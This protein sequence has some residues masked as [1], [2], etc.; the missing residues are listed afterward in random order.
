MMLAMGR[1]R[2]EN[3]KD[4]PKDFYP[5]AGGRG[6]YRMKNPVTGLPKSLKTKDKDEAL[7][8][9]WAIKNHY[10][11]TI[12]VKAAT[13][14]SG[15]LLSDIATQYRIEQLPIATSK[16]NPLDINTKKTYGN[17]LKNIHDATCF[18][19]PV[20]V[21]DDVDEGPRIVRE[22]LSKWINK[23]KTYN[24]RLSCLSRL[25]AWIVDM[26]KLVRNPC[27]PINHRTPTKREVYMTDEHYLLI[28]DRLTEKFG[29][30]YARALDW[31]YIMS[32]RPTNMM[33]VQESHIHEKEIHYYAYKNDSPVI[34]DRDDVIDELVAWFRAYKR[35]QG[36]FTQYLIVHPAKAQRGLAKRPIDSGRLYRYFKRA[37]K[38]VGLS[39]YTL[40]DI[41]PKALTDEATLA[42]EA[43]NKGA[44]K[45]QAMR[46]HYVKIK[47][48]IRV[49]NNLK[50]LRK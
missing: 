17:Y 47:P 41:R 8:L 20:S 3:N 38:D 42:G 23:P 11:P 28:R 7:E 35:A 22:Y 34:V 15:Q 9:Y 27:D 44:H 21:F 37:M 6:C 16:G 10:S 14:V 32:G 1:P 4:L 18:K 36:I 12:Q 46:E 33:D 31:L 19:V 29:E 24:Y 40:R 13:F 30:V 45:T 50:S 39:G 2:K 48:P 25:F 26:G 43:T 5:P 49:R